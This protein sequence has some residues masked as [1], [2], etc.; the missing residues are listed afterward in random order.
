VAGTAEALFNEAY[1]PLLEGDLQ[2]AAEIGRRAV[3]LFEQVGDEPGVAKS[4]QILA[5]IAE[6]GTD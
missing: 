6:H 2:A 1:V 3:A 5:F 4:E